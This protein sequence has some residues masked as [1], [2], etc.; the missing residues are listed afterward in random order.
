MNTR[1]YLKIYNQHVTEL[2]TL[3]NNDDI[4]YLHNYIEQNGIQAA[5]EW[6]A[7][8]QH[9]VDK[10][11]ISDLNAKQKLADEYQQNKSLA[12]YLALLKCF[13]VGDMLIQYQ[14]VSYEL[15]ENK[16]RKPFQ[17]FYIFS[18]YFLENPLVR[19]PL[20]PFENFPHPKIDLNIIANL[21]LKQYPC[22]NLKI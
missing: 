4:A 20:W 22:K 5:F 8:Y 2:L 9:L 7:N 1:E 19:I 12:V 10:L 6:C 3:V 18:T 11:L 14:N 13:F 16:H 15:D 17:M 21:D